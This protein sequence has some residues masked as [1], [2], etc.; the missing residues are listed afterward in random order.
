MNNITAAW[1]WA[2]SSV[3]GWDE[4]SRVYTG[5]LDWIP[6]LSDQKAPQKRGRKD[7]RRQRDWKTPEHSPLNQPGRVH[8]DGNSK[9]QV[10]W[11]Y[12]MIVSLGFCGTLT[13]GV[14]ISLTL[15]PALWTLSPYWVA[16][17]SFNMKGFA[18]SYSILFCLVL[19]LSLRGL[20][21]SG[22]KW[23]RNRSREGWSWEK[24]GGGEI[25]VVLYCM[26]GK[27]VFSYKINC[28]ILPLFARIFLPQQSE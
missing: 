2:E 25:V 6:P 7:C 18:L 21:F 12:V 11:I 24:L 16:L 19:L 3:K 13:M 15:L 28:F 26:R 8:R 17:S 4:T 27:S 1:R 14:G 10:L 20:L 22:G 23:S 9:H 5:A